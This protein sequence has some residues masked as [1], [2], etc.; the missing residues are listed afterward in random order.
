[1]IRGIP[2]AGVDALATDA[3]DLA[4][5]DA[6]LLAGSAI[7]GHDYYRRP[8]S[9]AAPLNVETTTADAGNLA[10]ADDP[11][12]VGTAMAVKQGHRGAISGV[13]VG[14]IDALAAVGAYEL[15]GM[16]NRCA[17]NNDRKT[18]KG[19][20]LV[21]EHSSIHDLTM[22]RCSWSRLCA[23]IAAFFFVG[24]RSVASDVVASAT[25]DPFGYCSAIG[26]IDTPAGGSSP[27]PTAL[28][29]FLSR[30]L[31]LSAGRGFSPESYY[32]RCMNGMVF[33]CAIGA[34]IPC[35][36]KADLAKHNLGADKYCQDNPESTFVPAYAT[37]H[38]T[39][40]AWSC[41]LGHAVPGKRIAKLDARG[42]RIDIW[43]K[44]LRDPLLRDPP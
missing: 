14:Y 35:G 30:A 9:R 42:Y 38:E 10:I 40:F 22:M 13:T 24:N 23:V 25:S 29:P 41:S 32:W 19:I 33:V 15:S 16:A 20:G 4:V 17:H 6:P 27:V 1:M 21:H 43:H 3:D 26:S 37:G 7:A 34:N 36:A 31:G 44:V 18:Q 8:I 12:L 5:R 11:L 2:S 39:L 28:K